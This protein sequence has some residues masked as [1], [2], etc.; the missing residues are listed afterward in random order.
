MLTIIEMAARF[1]DNVLRGAPEDIRISDGLKYGFSN[2]ALR[3][4]VEGFASLLDSLF[5]AIIENA[6][7]VAPPAD[8]NVNC[9]G[10]TNVYAEIKNPLTLLY[11]IGV[12]GELS[13]DGGRL[14]ADGSAVNDK[15]RKCRGNK[16]EEY[17][18]MLRGSGLEF[19]VDITAKSFKL[20]K[21]GT[22]EIRR[23][24]GGT[25]LIG[26]KI[27]AEAASRFGE[28]V[29]H[30]FTRN[31]F[32]ALALP[33]KFNYDIRGVTRFMPAERRDYLAG[34][35]DFLTANRCKYET[36]NVL[37]EYNF[38]YNSIPKKAKIFSIHISFDG[39][40]VKLNSKLIRERPDLL[41]S[42]PESIKN[43]VIN[44]NDCAKKYNPGAC[45]PK[46]EGKNLEFTLDGCSY[47]KCWILN[48]NLPVEKPAE[49]QFVNEWL[50]KELYGV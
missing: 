2:D 10:H 39:S 11:S 44:G 45:N 31:D 34:L 21:A 50:E 4:G 22:I 6:A 19:S 29:L 1:R 14:L 26:L 23:P 9:K 15:Y 48:F 43:A 16:P 7:G 32:N 42:A 41:D 25:A 38:I 27:I 8:D 13:G 35:H 36:K 20:K 37:N 24:D 3:N 17:L 47:L 40:D 46:C 18:R 12:C 28:D 33:K 5:G 30:I 49:R